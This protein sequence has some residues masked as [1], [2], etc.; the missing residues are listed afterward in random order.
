MV[1]KRLILR[2]LL[3][4][5]N[6]FSYI[7]LYFFRTQKRVQHLFYCI[8]IATVIDLLINNK[9]CFNVTLSQKYSFNM[10]TTLHYVSTIECKCFNRQVY[11]IEFC[12]LKALHNGIKKV[13]AEWLRLE[14]N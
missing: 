11:I 3:P 5:L 1:D 10:P 8:S 9:K 14:I 2:I 12:V 6:I 4:I 7:D 13:S